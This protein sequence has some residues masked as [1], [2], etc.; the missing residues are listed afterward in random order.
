MRR[1][2]LDKG[3]RHLA[4]E[5][6]VLLLY[7]D[8]LTGPV[9]VIGAVGQLQFEV[10]VDRLR[11]EYGVEVTLEML[12]FSAARWVRGPEGEI[13]KVAAGY[14]VTISRTG[15]TTCTRRWSPRRPTRVTWSSSPT[16]RCSTSGG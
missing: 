15:S 5:G 1:K 8:S 2:S 11:R 6:T 12:P 3:L 4:E 16:T 7:S 10:L 9:P 13:A 14:G